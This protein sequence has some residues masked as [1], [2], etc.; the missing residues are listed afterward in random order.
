MFESQFSQHDA[1]I[2]LTFFSTFKS[3]FS[4]IAYLVWFNANNKTSFFDL[5]IFHLLIFL[6]LVKKDGTTINNK[7]CIKNINIYSTL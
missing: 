3:L 1:E 7:D 4:L 2:F 6:C 5:Y